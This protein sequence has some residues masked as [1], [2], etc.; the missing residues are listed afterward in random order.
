[1]HGNNAGGGDG[2]NYQ[3]G[4]PVCNVHRLINP[5][6]VVGSNTH[7]ARNPVAYERTSWVRRSI[8]QKNPAITKMAGIKLVH[9]VLSTMD[10]HSAYTGGINFGNVLRFIS[11][12]RHLGADLLTQQING[13][14]LPVAFKLPIGPAIT[15]GRAFQMRPDLM[16]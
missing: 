14:F 3:S 10:R 11:V 15:A 6:L 13:H 7:V 16:D 2:R 1:M 5:L 12:F 4:K 8:K 9:A